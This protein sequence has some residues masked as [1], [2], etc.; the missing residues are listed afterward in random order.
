MSSWLDQKPRALVEAFILIGG[1]LIPFALTLRKF[2]F[3][4]A[5]HGFWLWPTLVS[6]PAAATVLLTRLL[7]ILRD[8][9]PGDFTHY[10]GSDELREFGVALFLTVYMLSAWYRLKGR[11]APAS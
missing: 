2:R 7:K 1:L 9:F 6:A 4:P 8:S 3:D 10:F 5:S 11:P